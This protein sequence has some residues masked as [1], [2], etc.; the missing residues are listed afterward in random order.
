LSSV[1]TPKQ[2][3]ATCLDLAQQISRLTLNRKP[4]SMMTPTLLVIEQDRVS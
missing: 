2:G 3:K 4:S 1:D